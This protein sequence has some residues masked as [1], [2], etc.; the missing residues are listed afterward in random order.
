MI[1]IY[2]S[3]TFESLDEC[4]EHADLVEASNYDSKETD[5]DNSQ[6]VLLLKVT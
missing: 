5:V 2:R 3:K 1:T 6:H 4:Y